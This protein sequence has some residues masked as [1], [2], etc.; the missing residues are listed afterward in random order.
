LI[1]WKGGNAA[2]VP[3][4]ACN[5]DVC[6]CA[7]GAPAAVP[8]CCAEAEKTKAKMTNMIAERMDETLDGNIAIALY[9]DG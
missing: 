1:D 5:S 2:S 8:F 3:V 7:A 6:C 4:A 9:L